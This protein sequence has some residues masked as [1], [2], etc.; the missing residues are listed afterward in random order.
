MRNWLV[1]LVLVLGPSVAA[2]SSVPVASIVPLMQLDLSR[3]PPA[4]LRVALQLPEG[5]RTTPGGVT[6]DLVFKKQGAPDRFEKLLMVETQGVEDLAGL[7]P[8][9]QPGSHLTAYRLSAVD[10]ERFAAIQSE[11]DAARKNNLSG[12]LGFGIATREFCL[13]GARPKSMQASTYLKAGDSSGWL[14]VTDRYDLTSDKQIA[15][16]LDG[17]RSCK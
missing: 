9:Q 6:L 14:T 2:C 15:Q 10:V 17:L 13:D 8:S 1:A 7:A 11:L 5:L 16:A 12:S 4:A 3:T